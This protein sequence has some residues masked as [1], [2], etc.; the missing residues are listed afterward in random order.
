MNISQLLEQI[1]QNIKTNGSNAITGALLNAV[2]QSMAKFADS[3]TKAT[4][5]S[6]TTEINKKLDA[7]AA[8]LT[9]EIDKKLDAQDADNHI[10]IQNMIPSLSDKIIYPFYDDANLAQYFSEISKVFGGYKKVDDCP[11][12]DGILE[13]QSIK[14]NGVIDPTAVYFIK[15]K[16]IFAAYKNNLFYNSW[17]GSSVYGNDIEYNNLTTK[18]L[19]TKIF[20]N[21]AGEIFFFNGYTLNKAFLSNCTTSEKVNFAIKEI[22][23]DDG[24]NIPYVS[25]L[26]KNQLI[27]GQYRTQLTISQLD[28]TIDCQYLY[29]SASPYTPNSLIQLSPMTG[30]KSG[31]AV[32]DWSKVDDNFFLNNDNTKGIINDCCMYENNIALMPSIYAYMIKNNEITNLISTSSLI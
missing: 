32:V 7:T 29:N 28:G 25:R 30:G 15:S 24:E 6:L 31:Y 27:D 5:A 2:L 18:A 12:F 21:F 4:D 8:S 1:N 11:L 26:F 9:T 19:K 17:T 10:L 3:G 13:R 22:W 20:Q 16:G 23:I 14:A